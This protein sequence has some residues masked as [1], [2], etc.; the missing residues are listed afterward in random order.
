MASASFEQI[1]SNAEFFRQA[2]SS[3]V[4]KLESTLPD[5]PSAVYDAREISVYLRT[6][7]L[8]SNELSLDAIN[9]AY[10]NGETLVLYKPEM[11]WKGPRI[12]PLVTAGDG[13]FGPEDGTERV[14]HIAIQGFI[15]LVL[16]GGLGS[17]FAYG[18]TGS[19]KTYT[20]T[21]LQGLVARDVF[22]LAEERGGHYEFKLAAFE[23]LGN[24]V[25]DLLDDRKPLKILEDKFGNVEVPRV[26]DYVVSTKEQY[27]ELI[28]AASILRATATTAKNDTSSRSHAV[29]RLTCKN[30]RLPSIKEGTLF[31]LDLAGSESTRDSKNHDKDRLAE[32][33]EINRSLMT[34]KDCIRSRA[35]A[36]T[37]SQSHIH[38]PYRQSKL[39]LLL[40]DAFELS[41]P[42][43]CHTAVIA[44]VSPNLLDASHSANTLKYVAPLKIPPPTQPHQ[45]DP[46]DPTTW[47]NE[48][49]KT[50]IQS[51]VGTSAETLPSILVRDDEAGLQL[52][53][54]S[55]EEFMNRCLK[56][57][58]VGE[59]KAK[60]L[61]LALWKMV[62][63]ARLRRR[64]KEK[65]KVKAVKKNGGSKVMYA[66]GLDAQ[67]R[68]LL[69]SHKSWWEDGA[70]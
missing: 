44:H 33:R 43:H 42:R 37:Q 69:E 60:T 68:V 51:R 6:R 63:D 21:G 38:I 61:Y 32:T 25:C 1:A 41:A 40:K 8:L 9:A 30:T 35:L 27:L 52:A 28:T 15:P 29:Y 59:K 7:P 56:S 13:C 54:L 58:E 23:I 46:D 17:V 22:Q 70:E 4:L 24:D 11:N 48:T 36:S 2:I 66:A 65:P 62:V 14:Y 16:G 34:L 55:E 50:W 53:K 10:A 12:S 45:P 67:D 3:E 57:G 20:M 39:T 26:K 47:T 49:C 64:E 31:L 5:A 18:Q 19:G